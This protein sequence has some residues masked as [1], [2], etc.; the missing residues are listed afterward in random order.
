MWLYP[1]VGLLVILAL[2]GGIVL[3]GVFTI[4]LVPLAIIAALTALVGMAMARGEEGKSGA[5]GG[6]EPPL[7][8]NQPRDPGHELASPEQLTD[9]RRAAQ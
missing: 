3:G 8:H 4:V 7:P 9:A 2:L 5:L 1:F 6:A